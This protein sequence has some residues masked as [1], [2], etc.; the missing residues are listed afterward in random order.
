MRADN[1]SSVDAL[2]SGS[3]LKGDNEESIQIARWSVAEVDFD[4]GGRIEG[5]TAFAV[6]ETLERS[7]LG[8]FEGL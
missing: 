5:C 8:K 6:V 4:D 2:Q 1:G 7:A 3:M